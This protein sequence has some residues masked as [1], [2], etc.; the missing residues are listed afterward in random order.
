MA[1]VEEFGRFVSRHP[2]AMSGTRT[3][4]C[5][6]EERKLVQPRVGDPWP[7]NEEPF[8]FVEEVTEKEL[9]RPTD[10]PDTMGPVMCKLTTKYSTRTPYVPI[11]STDV[12]VELL[13]TTAF[14]EWLDAGTISTLRATIPYAVMEHT[15]ETVTWID[16]RWIIMEMVNYV[17]ALP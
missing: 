12:S 16:P 17:N 6:W 2:Q 3:F 10:D 11:Q 13:E 1:L 4:I 7:D 5:E 15:Y 14:R 9:G 8:L